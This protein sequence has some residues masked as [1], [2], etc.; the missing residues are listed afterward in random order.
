MKDK[1]KQDHTAILIPKK[2]IL[3]D[4]RLY[5]FV[6]RIGDVVLSIL[7][8]L[9]LSPL[10]CMI[11]IFIK[12]DS[13]GPVIFA[14]ERLGKNGV[15]FLMYKFRSMTVDAEKD[16]PKWASENDDR[17]TRVGKILRKA[18]LDEIPQ[19]WNILEG[20]MSFV[21][22]R[23]ERAYFYQKFEAE[24][25]GFKDRLAVKPGLTGLAQI[26]GG[27]DL[28]PGEKIVYDMEYIEHP[29]IHLDV[30]CMLKTFTLIFTHKGAR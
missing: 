19:L 13:S 29:S 11:A 24:I 9:V 21:G 16:G 6:K 14:Q 20:D 23:P 10:M 18:R 26:N 7:L 25:P 15:P 22:P 2:S 1:F 27:Y 8:F 17:C 30:K 28:G 12:I 4:F 5:D 3:D